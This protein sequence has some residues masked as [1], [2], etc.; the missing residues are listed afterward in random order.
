MSRTP[1][2]LRQLSTWRTDST[3][4]PSDEYPLRLICRR[5]MHAYNS[6]CHLPCTHRS[7]PH[8]P[9]YLSPQDMASLALNDGDI[10]KL[11]S[12]HDW[13]YAIVETDDD[14]PPGLVSLTFAYG[15]SNDITAQCP[16]CRH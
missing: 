15:D 14:L 6:S 12:A 11:H 9:A 1:E 16:H 7:K 5:H 3:D 4:T 13:V 10:V 8:N 2:M